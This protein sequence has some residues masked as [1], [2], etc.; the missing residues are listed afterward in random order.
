[1]GPVAF[2][3]EA[4][5]A[6]TDWYLSLTNSS[7]GHSTRA[8]DTR[9]SIYMGP[10]AFCIEANGANTHWYL[11]LM[12][13]GTRHSTRALDAQVSICMGPIAFCTEANGIQIDTRAYW[14]QVPH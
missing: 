1:M 12:N 11:R 8:S 7:T 14:A 10:V 6:N 4:N 9:V 5:G 2:C 13:S 3:I